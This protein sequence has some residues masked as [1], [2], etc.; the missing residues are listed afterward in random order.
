VLIAPPV[1]P[2]PANRKVRRAF[3]YP[4]VTVNLEAL[5]RAS[6]AA[7][8]FRCQRQRIANWVRAGYLRAIGRDDRGR[9]LYRLRDLLE[10]ERATRRSPKSHRSSLAFA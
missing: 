2:Q 6:E 4:E 7:A 9:P 1:C 8:Y 3:A 10:A 5:L